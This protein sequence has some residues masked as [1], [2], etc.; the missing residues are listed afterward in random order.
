[1]DGVAYSLGGG[2]VQR[3]EVACCFPKLYGIYI[4]GITEHQIKHGGS[5]KFTM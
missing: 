3:V 1:M 4:H 2:V 5:S